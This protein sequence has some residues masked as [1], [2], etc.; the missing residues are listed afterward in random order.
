[1]RRLAAG[2]FLLTALLAM[3]LVAAEPL[4]VGTFKLD[5]TPLIGTPLCDGLCPPAATVADPLSIRGVVLVGAG[6]PIVLV[7]FDW[8]GIGNSGYDAFREAVARAVGT[9]ADRVAIHS[10]HQHDALGCDFDAET[11]LAQHGLSG[12]MFNV[13]DA[14]E[15]MAQL[16]VAAKQAVKKAEPITHIGLGKAKIEQVAAARRVLGDNGKIK[17]TRT[18]TTRNP[19]ARA[20]PEGVIDP[21]VQ[22]LSF[23]NGDRPTAILSYYATHPMSNYGKGEVSADFIGLGRNAHE[24]ATGVFQA[25]F[26]GGGGNV[27]AGKYNDGSLENRKIFT[28]RV[29]KGMAE[30][31]KATQKTPVTAADVKWTVEGVT[32]P[33]HPRY[34][35]HSTIEKQIDDA[36]LTVGK[37]VQQARHLAFAKRM[38]AGHKIPLQLLQLGGVN[39]LHMPGELFVEYQLAAQQMRP[40]APVLMAAYGD[41]GAGYICLKR[42]YDEGGYESGPVSRV[43]PEVEQV[44]M[45]AMRRLLEVAE[46]K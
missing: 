19:E 32:L 46:T 7:A 14:R 27:T 6:K 26:N 39:V 40:D 4:R 41:Y 12:A 9:D 25:H 2:C 8:V 22:L 23:W 18:S 37:R 36:K 29:E 28:D 17:Y 35:D 34:L 43:A 15:K 21:Y 11:I 3:P 5:G 10:L 20:E 13:A 30:A 1:M 42:S 31:W 44:L 38:A 33:V 16:A 45:S 24:R